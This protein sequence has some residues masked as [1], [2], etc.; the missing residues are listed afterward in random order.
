MLKREKREKRRRIRK[1]YPNLPF[2]EPLSFSARGRKGKK[3]RAEN[4]AKELS[5]PVGKSRSSYGK[6]GRRGTGLSRGTLSG[7]KGKEEGTPTSTE[8]KRPR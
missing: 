5:V 4:Q 8:K 2:Y 7:R 3:E 1:T 6:G